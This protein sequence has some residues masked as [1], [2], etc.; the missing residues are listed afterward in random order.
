MFRGEMKS[1]V[2]S[3]HP[4]RENRQENAAI[5]KTLRGGAKRPMGD[6]LRGGKK[7]LTERQ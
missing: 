5:M 6:W 7:S 2:E 4:E 3:D 1:K